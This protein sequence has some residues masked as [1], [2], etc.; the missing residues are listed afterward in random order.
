ML[1][2]KGLGKGYPAKRSYMDHATMDGYM[3]HF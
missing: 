3:Q 1:C 2:G